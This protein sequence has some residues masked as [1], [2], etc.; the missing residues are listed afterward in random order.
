MIELSSVS[1]QVP[2]VYIQMVA[3]SDIVVVWSVHS[4]VIM[5][6]A[7][8]MLTRHVAVEATTKFPTISDHTGH[9]GTTET[10]SSREYDQRM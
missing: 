7:C 9:R 6:I 1:S 4:R 10:V 2:A 5:A 3:A 8:A